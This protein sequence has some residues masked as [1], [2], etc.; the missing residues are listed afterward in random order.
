MVIMR[1]GRIKGLENKRM[2]D[3]YL[4]DFEKL[5]FNVEKNE[6]VKSIIGQ[7]SVVLASII[8]KYGEIENKIVCGISRQDDFIDIVVCLFV[9]KIMEQLDAINV[10]FSVASF[11]QAEVI[12]RSL[13]ENIVSFEFI[14]EE[15]TEKRAAAYFLEHHYQEIELGKKYLNKNS[16]Y[17]KLIMEHMGE[18]EFDNAYERYK[19]KEEAFNRLV[20][21]NEIFKKISIN[22]CKKINEKKRFN[23]K[24]GIKKKE[25]HI[26]WYEVCSNVSSFYGLMKKT[27][28]EKYYQGIYGGLS[29]ETHALNTTMNMNID[30]GGISLK[31]IRNPEGGENIFRIACDFS[32]SAL[33]K[34]YEYLNDGEEEKRKFEEFYEDFK[35]KQNIASNNLDRIRNTKNSRKS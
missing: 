10:L 22:R 5:F 24:K 7:A 26:Q 2:T 19:K 12:L 27:G 15:D 29:F 1:T 31:W 23:A 18:K 9:R 32:I 3:N 30:E 16:K 35:R 6:T 34:V 25:V 14:L 21:S 11:A 17:G 13:I 33:V 20:N 8:T 4:K 28:Y